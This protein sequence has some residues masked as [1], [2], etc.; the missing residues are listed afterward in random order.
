MNESKRKEREYDCSTTLI[1]TGVELEP[2][3]I[4]RL[5]QLTPSQTWRRG[6]KKQST[7][8]H[9]YEWGGWKLFIA[10]D[11]REFPLEEQLAYWYDLLQAKRETLHEFA[12]RDYW[13]R[14]DCYISTEA[15]ASICLDWDLQTKMVRIGVDLTL[16]I[17]ALTHQRQ[18][19]KALHPTAYSF[20]PSLVPRF[21]AALPAAGEL[22]R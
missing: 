14:L 5:L 16:S 21:V 7:T 2:D 15:T 10:D 19:N 4:T 18:P 1:I 9:V 6:E 17:Y 20:A 3:E 12:N 11:K 13:L 22:G 8:E